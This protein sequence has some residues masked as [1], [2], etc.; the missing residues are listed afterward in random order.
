MGDEVV[1]EPTRE[2]YG[3]RDGAFRDPAGSPVRITS[4]S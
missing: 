1:Q 4:L 3:C 2:P